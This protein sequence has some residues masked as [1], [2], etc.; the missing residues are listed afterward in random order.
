MTEDRTLISPRRGALTGWGSVQRTTVRFLGT[1]LDDPPELPSAVVDELAGQPGIA[2]PSRGKP[3]AERANTQGEHR[4]EICRAEG[5]KRSPASSVRSRVT[6]LITGPGAPAL[7]R[8]PPSTT[9][10]PIGQEKQELWAHGETTPASHSPTG[11]AGITAA[12][13]ESGRLAIAMDGTRYGVSLRSID[14]CLNRKV[15]R[16]PSG[17]HPTEHDQGSGVG[18]TSWSSAEQRA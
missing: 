18:S 4:R 9:H 13:T 7:A 8:K 1:F 3:Y 14:A 5:A 10:S 6:G 11:H 2:D 17:H 15:F 16:P 12:Q